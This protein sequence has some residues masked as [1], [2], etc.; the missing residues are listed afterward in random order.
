MVE[1]M[2]KLHEEES[3]VRPA[4]RTLSKHVF[5]FCAVPLSVC[6]WFCGCTEVRLR[7]S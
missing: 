7:W 2:V 1:M 6:R 5:S 3:F 4:G